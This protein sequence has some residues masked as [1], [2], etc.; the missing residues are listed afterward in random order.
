[1]KVYHSLK[2]CCHYLLGK[3]K[4]YF[5]S[6]SM[7]LKTKS[8]Y[9]QQWALKIFIFYHKQEKVQL[10]KMKSDILSGD[11]SLPF[12]LWQHALSSSK[13]ELFHDLTHSLMMENM[14]R[15]LISIDRIF[16]KTNCI[17][18]IYLLNS[19]FFITWCTGTKNTY[20]I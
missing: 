9:F 11:V 7:K 13:T 6:Q 17:S 8:P 18:Q 15:W 4:L 10:L 12:V 16:N 3:K 14:L 1:M 2:D 5:F 20:C 19:V